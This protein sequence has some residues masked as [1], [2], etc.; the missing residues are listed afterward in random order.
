MHSSESSRIST[1]IPLRTSSSFLGRDWCRLRTWPQERKDHVRQ[2]ER[3]FLSASTKRSSR[4]LES[5]AIIIIS[6]SNSSIRSTKFIRSSTGSSK[7][8]LWNPQNSSR[9]KRS[10]RNPAPLRNLWPRSHQQPSLQS[11]LMVLAMPSRLSST[12][13]S[14]STS[15]VPKRRPLSIVSSRRWK[16]WIEKC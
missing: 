3:W 9:W 6:V 11:L 10:L 2:R 13:S 14:T 15:T 5:S 1:E 12:M 4:R 7:P 8:T 16:A